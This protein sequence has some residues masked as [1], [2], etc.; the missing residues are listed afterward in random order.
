MIVPCV[1]VLVM[2]SMA[3]PEAVRR[4]LPFSLP[5]PDA[6]SHPLRYVFVNKVHWVLA[7]AYGC[8]GCSDV[9]IFNLWW[10]EVTV[11]GSRRQILA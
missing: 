6:C 9:N 1:A 10:Y 2:S 11:L 8:V 4:A 5:L 7:L 3:V